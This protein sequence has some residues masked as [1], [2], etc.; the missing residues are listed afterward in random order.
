MLRLHVTTTVGLIGRRSPVDVNSTFLVGVPL[1]LMASAGEYGTVDH[2][3]S[4]LNQTEEDGVP[5][6][7]RIGDALPD[8]S[9]PI[10]PLAV[11]FSDSNWYWVCGS[12][13]VRLAKDACEMPAGDTAAV[14]FPAAS[15]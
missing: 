4:P 5:D 13:E 14:I 10:Y 12:P 1:T 6:P 7:R 15:L 3:P 8:A 11:F 9:S 2:A